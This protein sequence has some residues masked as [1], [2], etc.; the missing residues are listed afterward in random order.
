MDADRGSRPSHAVPRLELSKLKEVRPKDYLARF[1]LGAL[2][3]SGA[4]IVVKVAGARF[5][6]M[7]LA[8]PAILPASLTL[9][10]EEEGTRMA[11]RNA[12]GAVLGGFGLAVFAAIV[13]KTILHLPPLLAVVAALAGWAVTA[14]VLYAVLALLR[15]EACDPAKD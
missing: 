15:P 9:V 2:I 6:G 7:L 13:E 10:Q 12:I 8:F 14:V 5:G 1:V 3:S 11:D 4:A